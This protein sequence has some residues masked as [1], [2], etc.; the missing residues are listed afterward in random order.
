[1]RTRLGHRKLVRHDDATVEAHALTFPCDR[2]PHL[3][4]PKPPLPQLKTRHSKLDT[5]GTQLVNYRSSH[6]IVMQHARQHFVANRPPAPFARL[7]ENFRQFAGSCTIAI[8]DPVVNP[9]RKSTL[10]P[11]PCRIRTAD[12]SPTL[13]EIIN[14]ID[15]VMTI[16][17]SSV[18]CPFSSPSVSSSVF[19]SVWVAGDGQQSSRSD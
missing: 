3:S 16:I 11:Q 7:C 9:H 4:N 6:S 2:P 12:R 5:V 10:S 15:G 13:I 8:A 19:P 17:T 14:E 18:R 1:M